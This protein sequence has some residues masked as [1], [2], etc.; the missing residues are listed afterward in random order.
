MR[1]IKGVTS[2]NCN[3]MVNMFKEMIESCFCDTKIGWKNIDGLS[4]DEKYSLIF[5]LSHLK[6]NLE[7]IEY[8]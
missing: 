4:Y 8:R 5:P 2:Q 3:I 6:S 1:E 7:A